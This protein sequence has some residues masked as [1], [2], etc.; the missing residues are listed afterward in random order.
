[1]KYAALALRQPTY[2]PNEFWSTIVRQVSADGNTVSCAELL[3][4][5]WLAFHQHTQN[6]GTVI[7]VN[8]SDALTA[9]VPDAELLD[10]VGAWV[11]ADLPDRAPQ[12]SAVA[13]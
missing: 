3:L 6:D 9:P 12:S 8:A 1:M 7:T 4:W 5:A 10:H 13:V 11:Q 2:T